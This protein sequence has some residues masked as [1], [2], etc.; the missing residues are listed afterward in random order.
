MYST[1]L[2][3]NIGKHRQS[4]KKSH[5]FPTLTWKHCNCVLTVEHILYTCTKTK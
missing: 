5:K 4:P 2:K 1:K 3:Q